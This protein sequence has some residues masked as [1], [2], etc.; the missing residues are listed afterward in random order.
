MMLDSYK[1]RRQDVTNKH[2]STSSKKKQVD[3]DSGDE[4]I[5]K[6]EEGSEQISD[7]GELVTSR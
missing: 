2:S 7:S 4:L 1:T 5:R 3:D 6:Y